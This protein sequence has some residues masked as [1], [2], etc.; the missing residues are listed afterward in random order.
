MTTT[1]DGF[2]TLKSM[3]VL[4]HP[5]LNNCRPPNNPP[6]Y[7]ETG[8]LHLYEQALRHYFLL[9]E[10]YGRSTFTGLDKSKQFIEGLDCDN[11]DNEK[12]RLMVILDTIELNS[13][14][15]TPKHTLQHLATTIMN[16]GHHSPARNVQ[17]KAFQGRPNYGFKKS[18]YNQY[19][20]PQSRT[21]NNSRSHSDK[22]AYKSTN[23]NFRTNK[24]PNSN[25]A[26]PKFE[27]IQC[28]ACKLYGHYVRNC[29]LIAT[30]LA[31]NEFSKNNPLVC[32]RILENHVTVN[33]EEHKRTIVRT[34]QLTGV[35]DDEEDSDSYFGYGGNYRH[36]SG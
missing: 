29:R 12:S 23:G 33:T 26:K 8:D 13:L 22:F 11:F 35:L 18:M 20:S 25:G 31:M 28:N 15:L 30:Y 19:R 32:S 17:V 24:F 10:I 16:M 27:K 9:H 21:N 5:S 2:Q 36:T 7:S 1:M 14:E 34:M 6:L 4:V 3:L